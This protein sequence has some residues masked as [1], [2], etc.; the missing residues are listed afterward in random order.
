MRLEHALSGFNVLFNISFAD[1]T[2]SFNR[3]A[4]KYVKKLCS[5]KLNIKHFHT[6]NHSLRPLKS[7][8][9]LIREH[10]SQSAKTGTRS[11]EIQLTKNNVPAITASQK[12]G[13]TFQ[14]EK[15]SDNRKLGRLLT[16]S[17]R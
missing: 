17:R 1:I 14:S 16:R 4:R 7:S 8:G 9:A 6:H 12:V 3:S 11:A 15:S 2:Y 5:L 10:L 13:F